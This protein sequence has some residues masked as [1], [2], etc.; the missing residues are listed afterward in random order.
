MLKVNRVKCLG[1]NTILESKFR[2]DFKRCGCKNSTFI[3]GGL[4]YQRVG[5]LDI[6]KIRRYDPDKKRWVNFN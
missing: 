5:A 1:C 6:D 3:D 4:D 2:H